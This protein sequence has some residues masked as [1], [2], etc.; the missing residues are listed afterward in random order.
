MTDAAETSVAPKSAGIVLISLILVAG[1][2]YG[3]AG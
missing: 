1:D 3:R 2:R